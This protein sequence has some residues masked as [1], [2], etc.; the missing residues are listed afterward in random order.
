MSN[1]FDSTNYPD[2]EPDVLYLGDQWNWKRDDLA[3]DYP[4]SSYAL[5]YSA[6]LLDSA[7]ATEIEISASEVNNSYL[8]SVASTATINY[9]AGEYS[10]RA[11]ITRASDSNRITVD[12]GLFTIEK[13][14]AT[15]SGDYRTHARI[16]LQALEATLESRASIDQMSM[17]IAGRSLSRMSPTELREWRAH[18][19]TLVLAEERKSRL[20]RGEG[21]GSTIKVQF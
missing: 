19:K 11:F 9:T 12:E 3:T 10:W 7:G 2:S 20:K 21:S 1:K 17:S 4:T 15:D 5:T 16:V 6:R 8:I 18:Y 13:D 14:Y